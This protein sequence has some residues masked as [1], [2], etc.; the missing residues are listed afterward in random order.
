MTELTK[1]FTRQ[2]YSLF[3]C[4]VW[5]DGDLK[6]NQVWLGSV[7]KNHLIL[8]ESEV[9]KIT[10][11]YSKE[12][13]E[14][15]REAIVRRI[16]FHSMWFDFVVREFY[17]QWNILLP[18][19]Q[20]DKEILSMDELREYYH[21]WFRWWAPMSIIF[22]IPNIDGISSRVSK[23]ALRVREDTQD[24][25]DSGGEVIDTFF[26]REHSDIADI[27]HLM[28][29]D[30]MMLLKDTADIRKRAF[31]FAL[32]NGVV[33]PIDRFQKEL[34]RQDLVLEDVVLNGFLEIE[35]SSACKGVVS[36]VVR[37]VL[38]NTQI[39]MIQ[40]GDI[41]VTEMT[42][43]E[44]VPAMKKAAA[45]V[46]DEGGITCHAAIVSRELQKPCIVGTKIATQVLKD[47]DIVEVNADKGVVRVL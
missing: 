41:L 16:F 35:G 36:G 9:D 5:S 21:A 31:G 8:R 37:R 39:N 29:L 11:W 7:L 18:Y 28:T 10:V 14:S 32:L 13:L 3:F 20:E 23:V 4:S 27:F 46:T 24:L 47:G 33:Y 43:P 2:Q 26:S 17:V 44:F 34:K 30:E 19:I 42:T 12:E 40:S 22:E 6:G 1:Y 15:Y 25:S 38:V 45:I